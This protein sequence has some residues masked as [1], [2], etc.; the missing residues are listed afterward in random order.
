MKQIVI[1]MCSLWLCPNIY[2]QQN[3]GIDNSNYAGIQ[4]AFLNPSSFVDSKLKWDIHVFSTGTLFDNNFLYIPKGSVPAFGFKKI[5]KGIINTDLFYSYFNSNTPNKLYQV[6]LSTDIMGPSFQMEIAKK[7]E[8][9]FTIAARSYTD[10]K[11]IPGNV[12]QNAFAYLLE[13]DLWNTTFHDNSSN[14]N[15]MTWLDYAIHY[16]TVLY[17]RGKHEIKGG[18]S[19]KYLQGIAAAYIKNTNLTYNIV[20]TS[21]LIFTNSSIDYGRTDYDSYRKI[22]NYHDLNHGVGFG[23]DIGF[24]YLHLKD[25]SENSDSRI[26]FKMSDPEHNNYLYRIGVSILDIGS[27]LFDRNSASYHLQTNS[28]NYSN[29]R[30]T[31]IQSN[32]QLDQALSSVFYQGDSSQSL[33]SNRFNMAL[34]TALSVQADWNVCGDFF[35]NATIVKSIG[36]GPRQGAVRPDIYSITPRYENEHFEF[37]LPFSVLYYNRWQPRIGLAVRIYYFYFGGDAPGSLLGLNNF[38][39]TD[40]YAGIH[41]FIPWKKMKQKP[42]S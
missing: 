11:N 41:Y 32:N 40:F 3:M 39:R 8:I 9:G 20:D 13:K 14:L 37:S 16:G 27:I 4:S 38:Q 30:S 15:S 19:L 36:H 28:A 25:P 17:R 18:V 31:H 35:A 22:S 10:I 42:V 34:P 23:G 33:V 2:A 21:K 29:W 24:T 1:F 7:H 5:F 6:T 26:G 12:A